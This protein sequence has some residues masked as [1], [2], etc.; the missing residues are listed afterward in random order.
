MFLRIDVH[1]FKIFSKNK[2]VDV[3]FQPNNFVKTSKSSLKMR[4]FS[5]KQFLQITQRKKSDFF[6]DT[7]LNKVYFIFTVIPL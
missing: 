7:N 2:A 5:T 1:N 6:F 3:I 4:D